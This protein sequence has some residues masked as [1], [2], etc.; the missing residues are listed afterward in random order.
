MVQARGAR[1]GG[2][3]IFEDTKVWRVLTKDGRVTGVETDQ[4]SIAC[5]YVVNCGGMWAKAIGAQAGVHIPLQAC[6]HF[7]IVPEPMEGMNSSLP[8]L[9]DMDA[10]A[11]YKEDAGK[12]LL[13]AFE[14]KAK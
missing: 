10:C 13:G 8:V 3:K 12:L 5:E 9:R 6:E 1:S 2:A 11:Y 14:P 4:G 7:Y